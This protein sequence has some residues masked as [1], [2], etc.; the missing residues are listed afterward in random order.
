M[1][2]CCNLHLQRGGCFGPILHPHRTERVKGVPLMRWTSTSTWILF[3]F[4]NTW[5]LR[6]LS[7]CCVWLSFNLGWSTAREIQVF[8][9]QLSTKKRYFIHQCQYA[10]STHLTTT[11]MKTCSTLLSLCLRSR[12]W[13]ETTPGWGRGQYSSLG[14]RACWVWPTPASPRWAGPTLPSSAP[15][16]PPITFPA[17]VT[18]IN[19]RRRSATLGWQTMARSTSQKGENRN[20]V[21]ALK[22]VMVR[23]QI[24]VVHSTWQVETICGPLWP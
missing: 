11:L 24:G 16:P 18:L 22:I 19:P 10:E 5:C 12:T 8:R 1:K 21:T 14:T 20:G 23:R 9:R 13:S 4:S 3:K 7:S 15:S 2:G 17:P 6:F